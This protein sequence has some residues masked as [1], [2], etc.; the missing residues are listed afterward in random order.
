MS[1]VSCRCAEHGHAR[2][3]HGADDGR[4]GVRNTD[5]DADNHG[6]SVSSCG[7]LNFVGNS[8][9]CLANRSN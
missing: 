9:I 1:G 6:V 3:V 2:G 4:T 5:D 7:R 8:G